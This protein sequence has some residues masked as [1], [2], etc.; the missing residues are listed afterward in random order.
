MCLLYGT[1]GDGFFA[2]DIQVGI[3]G[4]PVTVTMMIPPIFELPS[5]NSPTD[6]EAIIAAFNTVVTNYGGSSIDPKL[7]NALTTALNDELGRISPAKLLGTTN[8]FTTALP[9][10]G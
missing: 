6:L 1:K 9:K 10:N 5:V 4:G 2:P 8:C 7:A 3:A